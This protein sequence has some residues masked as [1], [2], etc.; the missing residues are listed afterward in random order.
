MFI[1]RANHAGA[2]RAFGAA[3]QHMKEK[4][5]SVWLFPEGTRSYFTRPDLLPFKKGAFHLA[6]QAGC[7]IVPVVVQNYAHLFNIRAR[8]FESGTINVKGACVAL[9]R[10]VYVLTSPSPRAH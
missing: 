6:I 9:R 10:M 3:V 1:D 5:Q 7:P 8:R 4:R 2:L